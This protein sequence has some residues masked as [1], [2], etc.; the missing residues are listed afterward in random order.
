MVYAVSLTAQSIQ[1]SVDAPLTGT[2]TYKL[3]TDGIAYRI[4]APSSAAAIAGQW[5]FPPDATEADDYEVRAT[6]NYGALSEG[7]TGS[8][9]SLSA[10]RSW[11]RRQATVGSSTCSFL[12]EIRRTGGDGTILASATIM[13]TARKNSA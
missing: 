3:G 10:D 6:M 8:W 11:T 4:S 7:V 2:A 12:V 1:S 5:L 9:L 13:L